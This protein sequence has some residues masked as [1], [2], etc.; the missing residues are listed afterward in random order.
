MTPIPCSLP[1]SLLPYFP[2]SPW[3]ELEL[4]AAFDPELLDSVNGFYNGLAF[5]ELKVLPWVY[6]EKIP[7]AVFAEEGGGSAVER[8]LTESAE[9]LLENCMY[10]FTTN[11]ATPTIEHSELRNCAGPFRDS[12]DHY[13]QFCHT[14]Y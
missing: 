11:P 10:C 9:V 7:S 1:R 13:Q 2:S 3:P 12:T 14:L 5:S 6:D 4:E 8:D